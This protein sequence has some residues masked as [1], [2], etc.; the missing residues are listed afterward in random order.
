MKLTWA[1]IALLLTTPALGRDDDPREPAEWSC[2][3]P[4]PQQSLPTLPIPRVESW[5]VERHRTLSAE[6]A[7]AHPRIVMLGDSLTQRW[8][9]EIWERAMAPRGAF[10]LGIN[11]D[12]VEHLAWRIRKGHSPISA[13]TLYVVMIGTNNVGRGHPLPNIAD[14]LRL[15]LENLRAIHPRTPI[16]LLALP[17]RAD[18]PD[19]TLRV[20]D[21]NRLFVRCA[22]IPGVTWGDPGAALLD[23]GKLSRAMAPDGLHFSAAGYERLTAALTPMI[24]RIAGPAPKPNGRR[25]Q[26]E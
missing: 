16:L 21:A 24:D 14:G 11:G 10:N 13:P 4:P 7:A 15:L 26:A 5:A 3:G 1:L 23:H 20:Q 2:L 17:P 25:L 9:P 12:R 22:K 19:L 6:L 8:D 18:R